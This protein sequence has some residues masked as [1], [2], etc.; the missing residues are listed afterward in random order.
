MKDFLPVAQSLM[1]E[2]TIKRLLYLPV[3][4]YLILGIKKNNIS[5]QLILEHFLFLSHFF[6]DRIFDFS[7]LVTMVF[8]SFLLSTCFITFNDNFSFCTVLFSL[9]FT[10]QEQSKYSP[11]GH[12]HRSV[13]SY[14]I[15]K[16][17]NVLRLNLVLWDPPVITFQGY[18]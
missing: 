7:E 13:G 5:L 17:N 3:Y 11:V 2:I 14:C 9:C 18:Y 6:L 16:Y 15:A 1:M 10:N 12:K 8:T 4:K